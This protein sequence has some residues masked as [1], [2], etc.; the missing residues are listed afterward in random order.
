MYKQFDDKDT[1]LA[2]MG[3]FFNILIECEE[4]NNGLHIVKI[5]FQ[6][7]RNHVL[8]QKHNYTGRFFACHKICEM[9]CIFNL[10]QSFFDL[11]SFLENNTE[12]NLCVFNNLRFK[13]NHEKSKN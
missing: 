11:K 12:Y 3:M 9:C 6:I 4:H 2:C 5:V 10:R 8:F 13:G 1:I 7:I